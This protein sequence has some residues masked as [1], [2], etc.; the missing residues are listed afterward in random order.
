M[1]SV[2]PDDLWF[3]DK[4][5]GDGEFLLGEPKWR[6]LKREYAEYMKSE[7]WADKR[8]AALE[9]AGYRCSQCGATSPLHVHHK[10]YFRFGGDEFERDLAVLCESCHRNA[11]DFRERYLKQLRDGRP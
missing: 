10:N 3:M 7:V 5:F 9:R 4:L 8:K 11:H 6:I 1:D 2:D